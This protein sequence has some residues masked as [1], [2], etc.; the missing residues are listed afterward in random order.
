VT[1]ILRIAVRSQV[2]AERAQRSA[3]ELACTVGLSRESTEEVVLATL[4]LAVNLVRYASAGELTFA[5][6]HG[7][8]GL[9]MEIE[10]RDTGPGIPD[11]E[12]VLQEG[13]STGGGL[14]GGL[15]G[16]RRLMDEFAIA[17]SPTGTRVVA[18]KWREGP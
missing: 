15:T 5:A 18:R 3:R 11:V 1:H 12:Q 16:V 17:S 4:E 10:S 6:L 14:G 13:F 9:G 7:P 2:D 8:R